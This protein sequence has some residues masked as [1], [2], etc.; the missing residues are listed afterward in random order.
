MWVNGPRSSSNLDPTFFMKS[1]YLKLLKSHF[2]NLF[3][4]GTQKLFR[5]TLSHSGTLRAVSGE[6][7]R[8]SLL[9]MRKS[10]FATFH[11]VFKRQSGSVTQSVVPAVDC[12]LNYGIEATQTKQNPVQSL[13][14]S[15]RIDTSLKRKSIWQS[16]VNPIMLQF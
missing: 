9:E 15:E 16:V 10:N 6:H 2:S 12:L 7:S 4:S 11:F 3:S 5:T 1:K 8:A 13:R 14:V